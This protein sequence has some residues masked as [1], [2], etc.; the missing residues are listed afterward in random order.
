MKTATKWAVAVGGIALAGAI[1]YGADTAYMHDRIPRGVTVA[2]IAI[3]GKTQEEAAALLAEELAATSTSPVTVVAGDATTTV[4]PQQAGLSVDLP[5]TLAAAGEPTYNPFTRLT[6]LFRTH[7]V[8]VVSQVDDTKLNP[9]LDGVVHELHRDPIDGAL[10]IADGSVHTTDAVDG[11]DVDRD[12]VRQQLSTFWLS[13]EPVTVTPTPIAP[14][15]TDDA[16]DR[17]RGEAEAAVSA[18]IVIT[19]RDEVEATLPVADVGRWLTFPNED[20]TLVR[21]FDRDG[22]VEYLRNQLLS[23]ERP[24]RNAQIAVTGSGIDVTPSVDGVSIDWAAISDT[25]E[26]RVLTPAA[27]ANDETAKTF[28]AHYTDIPATYTTEQAQQ[29]TFD[30]QISSFT[31]SG[32]SGPSGTNIARVAQMVDGAVVVPGETFSLN[33]YTGPRGVAQGFVESGIILN[34]HA[35]KAVGGGISQFATTLYNAAYFAGMQDVTHTPHSYYISRYPA[36]REATVFEGAIDLQ[37]KN[38]S[39]YPVLIRTNFGGGAITVSMYGVK[40]VEVQSAN[41]GRW[42]YTSPQPLQVPGANCIPSGGA[43]GFTTS[44]T[45]TIRDLSGAVISQETTTTV[46]DP[47]PIVRC[48]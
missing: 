45:R 26:Q 19:G 32:F 38:T 6:G 4:Q 17:L 28:A 34:G 29:A 31:T 33:G 12:D 35:D 18:P 48:G 11:Q 22:A 14:A 24:M 7:E 23:T 42:N 8:G 40:T 46:Y 39:P 47:Q 13:G 9:V 44:D 36:G 15:I 10:W 3:G 21:H 25:L 16:V 43:Q 37:F 5:A 20:G 30:Q 2:D 41:G 27:K 1:A